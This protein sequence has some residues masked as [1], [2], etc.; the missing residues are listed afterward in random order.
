VGAAVAVCV[1]IG[2]GFDLAL[3]PVHVISTSL[4]VVVMGVDF[5]V[6]TA[7]VGSFTGRRGTA[8]GVGTAVAA[9]SYLISSLAPVVR[10]IH[11]ARYASLFYWSVGND[12]IVNG[13]GIAG[14]AVLLC[15]GLAA[16]AAAVVG[17]QRLDL[18]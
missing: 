15:A 9:A 18:H 6:L 7:A 8:L 13:V 4:A 14:Y 17:F 2:R 12:Q 11:P 1:L 5:G 3:S 16:A 10:W